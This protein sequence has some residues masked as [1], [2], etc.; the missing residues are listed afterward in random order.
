[1]N[2]SF[3]SQEL[4]WT[5]AMKGCVRA[6]IV[7]PLEKHLKTSDFELSVHLT[8]ARKKS[9]GPGRRMEMWIVLQTFDGR[10]NEVVRCEGTEFFVLTNEISSSV[11]A[12]LRKKISLPRRFL[13][14]PF[15]FLPFE[16]TA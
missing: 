16:R 1:M 8:Y 12:R 5:E 3:V 15:R 2:I 6:K 11:R 14:N 10:T 7:V 9:F 13:S 4:E